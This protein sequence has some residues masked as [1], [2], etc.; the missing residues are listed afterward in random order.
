MGAGGGERSSVF[1][2]SLSGTSASG[3]SDSG[4][5]SPLGVGGSVLIAANTVGL[6]RLMRLAVQ[7]LVIAVP[8][9][10]AFGWAMSLVQRINADRFST[11]LGGTTPASLGWAAFLLLF[12]L[13]MLAGAASRRSR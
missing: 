6:T 3:M 13:Q 9:G 5:W 2:T 11:L 1:G 10:V 8:G 7:A 12:A 4:A